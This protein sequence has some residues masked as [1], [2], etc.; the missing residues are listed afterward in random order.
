[1]ILMLIYLLFYLS[2]AR[3]IINTNNERIM[4]VNLLTSKV[5]ELEKQIEVDLLSYRFNKNISTLEL[6]EQ[7]TTDIYLALDEMDSYL[8][9]ESGREIRLNFITSKERALDTRNDLI[10][11][12]NSN[13]DVEINRNY[14]KWLLKSQNINATLQDL[15]NYNLNTLRRSSDVYERAISNVYNVALLTMIS[16]LVLVVILF[17]YLRNIITIPI[18]RITDVASRISEGHF[19]DKLDAASSDELGVLAKDLNKMALN[20]QV[21]YHRLER[22]VRQK[23]D[24][25]L[26]GRELERRKDDFISMASHELKTPVTS[27]KV[28]TQILERSSK[29][30]GDIMALKYLVRMGDQIDRLTN[31]INELLDVSRIQTGRLELNL[32]PTSLRNLI[33]ETCENI[34]ATV[35]DHKIKCYGD[36]LDIINIDKYRTGQV[37]VNLLTNAVKYSPSGGEVEMEYKNRPDDVLVSVRDQGIGIP[38]EYHDRI[39]ERFYRVYDKNEKTFPGLGMGLYISSEIIKKHG[40]RIWVES[41]EGEGSTFYFTLPKNNVG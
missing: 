8:Q 40:G 30:K 24:A 14:Q 37:L 13:S 26:K 23:E 41:K 22:E 5:Y 15:T 36:E 16:T 12:I 31:I 2:L 6:I 25:L 11:A 19:G 18:K 20:L 10:D 28:F 3:D 39:F 33:E 27:I 4:R 35:V 34:Q 9:S 29:E 21:N 1:M 32:E 7:H 38:E 17:F